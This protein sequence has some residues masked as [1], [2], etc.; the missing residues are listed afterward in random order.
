MK[1]QIALLALLTTLCAMPAQAGPA[2]D[3]L[4]DCMSDHTSGKDRKDLARWIFVSMAVHPE[5]TAL[6]SAD[7][8][9]RTRANKQFAALVTRLITET[10]VQQARATGKEEGQ[11]GVY[12]AFKRLGEIAMTELM[13]HPDVRGAVA[14]YANHLD[15]QK[16][17]AALSPR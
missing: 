3:S 13:S 17:E 9:V 11:Q 2:A 8:D 5:L 4:A 16:I 7:Q 10:C 12:L 6:S 1:N 15:G 14:A